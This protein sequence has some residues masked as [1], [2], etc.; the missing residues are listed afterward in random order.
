MKSALWSA[1]FDIDGVV[2]KVDL[3]RKTKEAISSILGRSVDTPSAPVDEK[4]W[5]GRTWQPTPPAPAP[6]APPSMSDFDAA[7]GSLSLGAAEGMAMAFSDSA[8]STV[9]PAQRAAFA[10]NAATS[11]A[12]LARHLSSGVHGQQSDQ[13]PKAQPEMAVAATPGAIAEVVDVNAVP[14]HHHHHHHHHHYYH[15]QPPTRQLCPMIP[16][17]A[18]AEPRISSATCRRC[19][20]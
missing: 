17:L 9:S 12:T 2:E 18:S 4:P 11:A 16:L 5:F 1:C 14:T 3:V 8:V 20:P 7:L 15:Q 13:P 6:A 19:N 10:A